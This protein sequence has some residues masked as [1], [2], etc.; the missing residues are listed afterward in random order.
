MVLTPP[1]VSAL[2]CGILI[3]I[4]MALMIGVI[5]IRRRKKQSL[6]DG[7]QS[8]LQMAIRRH[9]NF[10]ENAAI[11]TIGL[12]LLEMMGGSRSNIEILCAIFVLGRLSHAIG[13]SMQNSVNAFRTSGVVATVFVGLALGIRLVMVSM[14]LL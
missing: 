6:G 12:A 5:I 11:F 9:G 10:A 13:L 14:S 4:Q 3:I 2:M 1:I 8:D 7:G